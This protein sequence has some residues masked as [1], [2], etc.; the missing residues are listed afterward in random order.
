L[1]LIPL[2]RR[3]VE[4]R[5][6]EK[7]ELSDPELLSR[8]GLSDGAMAWDDLL[9]RR[10]VVILAEAGSGKSE[11]L[12]GQA[13]RLTAD[14]RIAFYATVH[15]VGQLGLE[16][17]ISP[18][19]RAKIGQWRRSDQPAW[20]FVDS[21]DEAKLNNVRLERAFRN[22]ADTIHNAEGR[23][24]IV[25]TSRHT[26]WEFRRDLARLNEILPL[27]PDQAVPA[28]PAADELLVRILHNEE[29]PEPVAPETPVVVV[30]AAL[31][32][33]RVRIFAQAK[34]ASNLDDLV[35]E[36]D[37][38]NLWRFARRPLDLDWLVQFWKVNQQLGPLAEMLAASLSGRLRES[39]PSRARHDG[40][41]VDRALNGLERI[42]AALTFGRVTTLGIPDSE[43]AL[44]RNPRLELEQ[45]LPDWSGR[46]RTR[47]LARPV[48]DPGTF[49]RVRLHNDNEGVVR[50]YLAA[51]WL[52]RLRQEN[53]SRTGLFTLL[54]ADVYGLQ[55]VKP[56]LQET[57]AWLA[58]WNPDVAREVIHREPYVLLTGGDPASLP[59]DVRASALTRIIERMVANNE[60][61]PVL[62]Y[63]SVKR[64]ARPDLAPVIRQL[65]PIHK[66][67]ERAR[68]ALL[69]LIWLGE[70]HECADLAAVAAADTSGSR[71]D[72]IVAGRAFMA[73]ADIA[74][75]T[76]YAAHIV[77]HCDSRPPTVVW[78]AVQKL[79]P[80]ILGVNDLLS[81]LSRIDVTDR[82]GGLG[83]QWQSPELIARVNDPA[84]LERL[85]AGLLILI[86]PET[87][88][89]RPNRDERE[90]AFLAAIGA[91]AHRLLLRTS[92]DA[93]SVVTVDAVTRIGRYTRLGGGSLLNKVGDAGAEL[94]KTSARRRLAFWRAAEQMRGDRYLQGRPVQT[95][96]EMEFLGWVPGLTLEDVDWLLAD[97]PTR[98]AN[99]ERKL[100]ANAAL[101]IWEHAGRPDA[102]RDHIKRAAAADPS[103][104][105]AYEEW[106]QP[107]A[108]DP[109]LEEAG[110]SYAR[111]RKRTPSRRQQGIDHGATSSIGCVPI[112]INFATSNQRQPRAS[113]AVCITC[114]HYS[115]RRRVAIRAMP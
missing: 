34:G 1:P 70:L 36:I 22:I 78:D 101:H 4:W 57:A 7:D 81:I 62:D 21:I 42:G 9:K 110:D 63:D 14:D 67:H 95:L 111:L 29:L 76:D 15:D 2:D 97:G 18:A 72:Q 103:M 3:F 54:F 109:E 31:D 20:F 33:G 17:A 45:V 59:P 88:R 75:K 114:G 37:A 16:N 44:T 105:E 49:G 53:L 24:H 47:L 74:K 112:P 107:H 30:L 66:H 79:F 89:G 91:A 48:F 23:A 28:A 5:H 41:D 83:F 55:L 71:Y 65:W 25:L 90:E 38:S 102:V 39:D 40:I 32:A 64:F 43:I 108:P 27:P 87:N 19:D 99:D 35:A 13:L 98:E 10:R 106:M 68:D 115:V 100:A 82:D 60:E 77:H 52:H 92:L 69:R 6:T 58:I 84:D 61:L 86:G 46:D 94:R 113:T 93:A 11:E 85:L 96:W 50:A 8:L 26:D 56:S 12:K 80:S 73:T 51:R 104:L